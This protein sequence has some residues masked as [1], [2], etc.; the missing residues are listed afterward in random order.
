MRM[1]CIQLSINMFSFYFLVKTDSGFIGANFVK[2][3]QN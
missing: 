3:Y 1:V 2:N